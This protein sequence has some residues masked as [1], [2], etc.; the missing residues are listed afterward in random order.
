[1]DGF[2]VIAIV[3]V[4]VAVLALPLLRYRKRRQK[5]E[6][7]RPLSAEQGRN[8][9]HKTK[10][11]LETALRELRELREALPPAEKVRIE[12]RKSGSAGLQGREERRKGRA[13]R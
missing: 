10:R 13:R 2:T 8:A 11:K 6:A 5:E 3:V 1:M 9:D 7:H 4:V 12:R